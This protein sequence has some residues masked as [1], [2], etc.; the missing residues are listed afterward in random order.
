MTD[1]LYN[2][3][4]VLFTYRDHSSVMRSIP[5]YLKYFGIVNLYM[6]YKFELIM[7]ALLTL[8][9]CICKFSFLK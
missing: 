1:V 4:H 5:V 2:N 8:L 9:V 3:R 6:F 7:S